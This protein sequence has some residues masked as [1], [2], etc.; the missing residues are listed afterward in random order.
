MRI[1]LICAAFIHESLLSWA[2]TGVPKPEWPDSLIGGAIPEPVAL[3]MV[4]IFL[5]ISGSSAR[6]A[7]ARLGGRGFALDRTLRLFVPFVFGVVFVSTIASLGEAAAAGSSGTSASSWFSWHGHHLAYLLLLFVVSVL[8]TPVL[9]LFLAARRQG[10]C[11]APASNRRIPRACG[12]ARSISVA[13]VYALA[14]AVPVIVVGP[15][16]VPVSAIVVLIGGFLLMHNP[17]LEHHFVRG[18]MVT[19]VLGA[20]ALLIGELS[21]GPLSPFSQGVGIWTLALALFALGI[22]LLRRVNGPQ[23]RLR[24]VMTLFYLLSRPVVLLTHSLLTSPGLSTGAAT[25]PTLV[26]SVAVLTGLALLARSVTPAR[27]FFGLSSD[28]KRS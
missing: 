25:L 11:R 19:S 2:T 6:L 18:A 28:P 16:G 17:E 3:A 9:R 12:L 26:I 27:F 23:R 14:P 20:A 22:R 7:I 10:D 4:G 5:L 24:E 21:A 1:F 8:S 13:V 15:I